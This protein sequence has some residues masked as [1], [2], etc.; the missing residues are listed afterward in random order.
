MS[1]NQL[2]LRLTLAA[3][4]VLVLGGAIALAIYASSDDAA[5]E[6][7]GYIV[8]DGLKYPVDP[9]DS[10]RYKRDLEMFGGKASVLFDEWSRWFSRLWQGKA[11]GVTIGALSTLLSALLL[12][13]ARSLPPD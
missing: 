1:N 3:L 9:A 11:L 8:I 2:R 4:V 7:I 13:L 5:P 12:L 6:S 10:K